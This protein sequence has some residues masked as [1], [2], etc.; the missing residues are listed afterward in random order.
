[1][2]CGAIFGAALT[3]SAAEPTKKPL[4][5]GE[6]NPANQTVDL[7]DA[8]KEK[9]VEVKVIHKDSSGGKVLITNKTDQGLNLK[10][11]D[12]V[13]AVHVLPQMMGGMAGGVG[14]GLG[15]SSGGGMGGMGGGGMGGMG[16]G[17]GGGG[18]MFNIAPE[19][20]GEV[21]YTSVCLE[22][23]KPEP[24]AAMHYELR[25]IESV[26]PKAEVIEVLKLLDKGAVPQRV[27]QILAWH[28]NNEMSFEQLAAKQIEH[29]G[30]APEPYFS[31]DE[32]RAAMQVKQYVAK[33]LEERAKGTSPVLPKL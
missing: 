8:I 9:Q 10:L 3:V 16:G 31:L 1:M 24:K 26:A 22:H 19:K 28:L 30:G 21:K 6:F 7:F 11:P 18:G 25:P 4:K 33:T 23:G 17:L 12:A 29:L 20:V 2:L 32:I 14:G 13:A 27:A 5:P 15:Q